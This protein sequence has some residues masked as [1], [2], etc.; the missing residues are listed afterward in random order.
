MNTI[1]TLHLRQ[2]NIHISKRDQDFLPSDNNSA[3]NISE[4]FT[5]S[6]D[7]RLIPQGYCLKCISGELSAPAARIGEVVQN[8]H[9]IIEL[10]R[11]IAVKQVG[12]SCELRPLH[13]AN[14]VETFQLQ[15]L[16]HIRNGGGLVLEHFA[17]CS[18]TYAA[19]LFVA[20]FEVCQARLHH[21]LYAK[22]VRPHLQ[23][24]QFLMP[25]VALHIANP[26]LSNGVPSRN[27]GSAAADERLKIENKVPPAVA[28]GLVFHASRFAKEERRQYRDAYDK[29]KQNNKT[30]LV[31][32]GHFFPL[33]PIP[34]ANRSHFLRQI[35]S[36]F[37]FFRTHLLEGEKA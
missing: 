11:K 2:A 32:F 30:L 23:L 29:P 12:S 5:R 25:V 17:K 26:H 14:G 6:L 4:N 35:K 13:D 21:T 3:K 15:L 34:L 28:A 37:R 1:S 19:D 27:Y 20:V 33:Q 22:F 8:F 9:R 10:V 18:K 36:A 7:L 31:V 24:D 16:Q